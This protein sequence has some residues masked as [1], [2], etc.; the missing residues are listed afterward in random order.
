MR[1]FRV[2]YTRSVGRS[3]NARE[4]SV[5]EQ[6]PLLPDADSPQQQTASEKHDSYRYQPVASVLSTTIGGPRTQ[7]ALG[8]AGEKEEDSR[9][10]AD[11]GRRKVFV[12]AQWSAPSVSTG[13]GV[14][15]RTGP[16]GMASTRTRRVR[17]Q[18]IR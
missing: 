15:R 6:L 11:C 16:D 18:T 1:S 3:N 4:I 8:S 17:R 12:H 10:T 13:V 5:R 9:E 14:T 2:H 7:I